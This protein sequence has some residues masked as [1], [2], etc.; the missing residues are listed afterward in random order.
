MKYY[1]IAVML[2]VALSVLGCSGSHAD[3][4]DRGLSP[5]EKALIDAQVNNIDLLPQKMSDYCDAVGR[6]QELRQ[7]STTPEGAAYA[8][9][10]Q[11]EL[12]KRLDDKAQQLM[13]KVARDW[14]SNDQ[15]ARAISDRVVAK[16][17][18]EWEVVSSDAVKPDVSSRG[19]KVT[20]QYKFKLSLRDKVFLG[21]DRFMTKTGELTVTATPACGDESGSAVRTSF[22]A[23][24]TD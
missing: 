5:D 21:P 6:L 11:T 3:E 8:Q 18:D 1:S 23:T 4:Y 24:I 17:G 22:K 14:L 20:V 10:K 12:K 19:D 9:R 2:A 13:S 16:Y 15:I 7:V